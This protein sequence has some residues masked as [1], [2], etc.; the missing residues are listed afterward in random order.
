MGLQLQHLDLL[1]RQV[2]VPRE[3]LHPFGEGRPRAEV[4]DHDVPQQPAP[5]IR[6]VGLARV[7]ES[8]QAAVLGLLE[9]IDLLG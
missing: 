1:Q 4:L 5:G 8:L 3:L 7:D 6:N 2:G 9:N